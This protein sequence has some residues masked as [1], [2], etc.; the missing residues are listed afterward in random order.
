MSRHSPERRGKRRSPEKAERGG[1]SR[2]KRRSLSP[3]ARRGKW[4]QT[5]LYVGNINSRTDE[6]DLKDLFKEFGRIEQ[7][8]IKE[9]FGFVEFEDLRDAQ[10]A[11]REID[12][13]E[14]NGSRVV[15]EFSRRPGSKFRNSHSRGR[16]PRGGYSPKRKRSF[17]RDRSYG[18]DRDRG[19]FGGRR[20]TPGIL[21]RHYKL[22][23]RNISEYT[24]W[25]DLK[26]FARQAGSS[27]EYTKVFVGARGER[28]GLIEYTD[29]RDYEEALKKLDGKELDG[30][31][32]K[33]IEYGNSRGRSRSRDRSPRRRRSRSGE[34]R[35]R[36]KGRS[37]GRST[38][39]EKREESPIKDRL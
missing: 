28:V 16:S 4:R 17:S 7:V 12:G 20:D 2:G 18:R 22:E 6:R 5:R 24:S 8:L 21:K 37:K 9:G 10:R 1:A 38:S 11:K 32:V 31:K 19:R 25:Q 34:R 35:S 15:V 26:D 23:V 39:L 3:N 36:S 13:E 30:C 14:I 27:V 33:L 29:E